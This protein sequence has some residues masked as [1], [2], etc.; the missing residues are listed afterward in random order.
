MATEDD[1][2]T[3]ELL[4]VVLKLEIARFVRDRLALPPG[5]GMGARGGD[6]AA[7]TLRGLD[8][9]PPQPHELGAD[10][11]ERVADGRADLDL[12]FVKLVGDLVAKILPR[13]SQHARCARP[14]SRVS[15]SI[16]WY[17]SSTPMVKSSAVPAILRS[18]S[19]NRP[20]WP[21]KVRPTRIHTIAEAYFQI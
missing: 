2:F 3:S 6:A 13:F 8:N 1:R 16:I 7:V 17:S 12:R 5:E 19:E 18:S 15:G 10:I 9:A 4:E 11:R 20:R 21:R 14:S